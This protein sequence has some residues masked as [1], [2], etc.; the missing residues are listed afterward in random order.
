[1]I[2]VLS[3]LNKLYTA[4]EGTKQFSNPRALSG[5]YVALGTQ[6]PR[7]FGL[8]NHLVPLVSMPNYYLVQPMCTNK[9]LMCTHVLILIAMVSTLWKTYL[10]PFIRARQI[11]NP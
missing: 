2:L 4:I 8:L 1:M 9:F 10:L 7:A 3:N 6:Q 5:A 11:D